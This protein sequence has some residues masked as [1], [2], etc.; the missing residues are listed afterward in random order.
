MRI[1]LNFIVSGSKQSSLG[2]RRRQIRA[3]NALPAPDEEDNQGTGQAR[4]PL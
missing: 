4:R 1:F 2:A 3:T